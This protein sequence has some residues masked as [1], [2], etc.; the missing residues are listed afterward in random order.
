M[1]IIKIASVFIL[2]LFFPVLVWAQSPAVVS[3]TASPTNI[4]SGYPVSFYWTLQNAGGYSF[5]FLCSSGIKFKIPNG[6]VL[7]CDTKVSST[8]KVND[9]LAYEIYN[10]SGGSKNVTVRLVPKT[11]SGQDYDTAASDVTLTVATVAQPITNFSA[12]STITSSG[13]SVTI[14][15]TS[16]IIEG[17]NLMIDCQNEVRVSAPGKS[18]GFLPCQ[19]I[20]FASDFGPTGSLVLNFSNS[21]RFSVPL[22]L[23]LLP[24][25]SSKSYD[26]THAAY[27]NLTIASD[28]LPDPEVASFTASSS[29][30]NSG[31]GIFF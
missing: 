22:K 12:D 10:I 21:S 4:N 19:E 31:D 8:S 3:F 27:L 2:S 28:V 13:K 29:A 11:A 14:N 23:T 30:I 15:W 18:A 6:A 24:A 9:Y 5:Y 26:G 25:I 16:Q 7:N 20:A 17:V 1:S